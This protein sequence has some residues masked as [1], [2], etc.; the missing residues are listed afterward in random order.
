MKPLELMKLNYYDFLLLKVL[1]KDDAGLTRLQL[2]EPLYKQFKFFGFHAVTGFPGRI[3]FIKRINFLTQLNLVEVIRER[4][5]IYRVSDAQK[6]NVM[7][8]VT[9][10]F[11]LL[12][13]KGVE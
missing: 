6:P 5:H 10:Y 8:L 13:K 12:N 11:N 7:F 3:Y 2:Q 1:L 4:Q 9:G